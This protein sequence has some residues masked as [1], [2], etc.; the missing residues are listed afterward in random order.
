MRAAVWRVHDPLHLL[1]VLLASLALGANLKKTADKALAGGLR[2]AGGYLAHVGVGIILLGM[3]LRFAF[4]TQF[5]IKA[6]D[7]LNTRSA[8]MKYR[9]RL[10]RR[11]CGFGQ[12]PQQCV[13]GSC[14]AHR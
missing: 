7:T 11:R 8:A 12:R 1:F 4:C 6:I 13:C 3:I 14:Y 10:R 9:G 5:Q 2:A